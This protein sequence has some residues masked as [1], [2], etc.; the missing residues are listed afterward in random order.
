[1]AALFWDSGTSVNDRIAF[2]VIGEPLKG[3]E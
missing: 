3:R 1:M 2:E